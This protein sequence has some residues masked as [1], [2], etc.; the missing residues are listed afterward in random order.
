MDNHGTHKVV[1]ARA[2]LTRH[3]RFH[4]NFTPT[5]ASWIYLVER[6]FA[7]ITERCVRRGT[8]T[9]VPQLEKALLEYLDH[10]KRIPSR[11]CGEDLPQ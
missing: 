8:H 10:R 5:S 3:P 11:S 6:L 1:H 2:W 4:V 7:E 9:A